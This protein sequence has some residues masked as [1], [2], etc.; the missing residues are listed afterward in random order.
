MGGNSG[1]TTTQTSE[2]ILSPEQ[3]KIL[4]FAMPGIEKYANMGPA[5]LY[6][7]SRIEGFNPNQLQAQQML[8]G[9][10]GNMQNIADN[11]AKTSNFY[12]SGDIWNPASN[13]YLSQ[14]IDATVR[15]ITQNYQEVVQPGLRGEATQTGNFGSSRQGIAEGLA[16]RNYMRETG[17]QASKLVQNQY[18]TNIDAQMKAL[19]LA[20]QTQQLQMA[21]SQAYAQVGDAQRRMAQALLDEKVQRFNYPYYSPLLHS[22]DLVGLLSSIPGG[23]NVS[24]ATQEGGGGGLMG[25]LGMGMQGLGL[26]G[27]LFGGGGGMG[28]GGLGMLLPWL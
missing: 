3:Q 11:A 23:K 1:Q 9:S 2:F 20:P 10:A 6:P 21:P 22:Q 24:T 19:G 28:A 18:A 16:A 17:D 15:P 7:G 8:L 26:L 4:G 5:P 14:A 12:T 27:S 13:P 25:A